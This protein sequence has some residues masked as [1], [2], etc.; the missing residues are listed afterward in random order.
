MIF[1][2]QNGYDLWQKQERRHISELL[3][4]FWSSSLPFPRDNQDLIAELHSAHEDYHILLKK[5]LA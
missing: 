1:Q 5:L 4:K 2:T 3:N